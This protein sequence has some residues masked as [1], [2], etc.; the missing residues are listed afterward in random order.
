MLKIYFS[1]LISL[2][3]V[4]NCQKTAKVQQNLKQL[5]QYLQ[6]E[7]QNGFYGSVLLMEKEK[8]LFHKT[9]GWADEG[10]Q[11]PIQTNTIFP[12]G[13]IVK[14]YTKTVIFLLAEAGQLQLTDFLSVHFENIPADKQEITLAHLIQHRSGLRAYHD[15]EA[16]KTHPGIPGDFIPMTQ[17]EAI[18][19]I[20]NQQLKFAPGTDNAYSNSGY[21]LLALIIEKI[22]GEAF[23]VVVNEMILKQAKMTSTDFY[24]SQKWT[25]EL[26][27]KG[28]G[29]EQYGEQNSPLYW[30]RNPMP[31]IGN[32]GMAGTL[33]DFYKGTKYLWELRNSTPKLKELYQK[34]IDLEE[35]MPTGIIG[36]A[37]GN[38]FGFVSLVFGLLEKDQY[39]IFTTNNDDDGMEDIQMIQKIVKLGFG[40]DITSQVPEGE[41]EEDSENDQIT[42][43]SDGKFGLPKG[44]KWDRIAAFL[45]L[46]EEKEVNRIA[47][48]LNEHTSTDF[49]QKEL[50]DTYQKRFTEWMSISP[51]EVQK[52]LVEDEEIRIGLENRT[53]GKTTEFR[54]I[55]SSNAKMLFD[56]IELVQD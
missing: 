49:Q 35:G 3:L 13:S 21:T 42:G 31:L 56:L 28:Y 52:L 50:K 48:F 6:T 1:F 12:Y 4:G 27:A 7:H 15:L 29:P 41:L 43:P 54:L 20:F 34:Y 51:F 33:Q 8:V 24:Q 26:V 38:D 40:I 36:S 46:L 47:A 45:A 5:D 44:E 39:L 25:D 55:M 16:A 14:D 19:A 10:K 17:E 53:S 23:D 2:L 22:T 9:Y 37:G 11:I 30:P 18:Q 32:G